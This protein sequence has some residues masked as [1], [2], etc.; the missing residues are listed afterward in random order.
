MTLTQLILSREHCQTGTRSFFVATTTKKTKNNFHNNR[1][2]QFTIATYIA[3]MSTSIMEKVDNMYTYDP[4]SGIICIACQVSVR[5]TEGRSIQYLVRVHEGLERHKKSGQRLTTEAEQEYIAKTFDS[6]IVESVKKVQRCLPCVDTANNAFISQIGTPNLYD[7]CTRCDALTLDKPNHNSR[8]CRGKL[9]TKKTGVVNIHCVHANPIIVIID[10]KFDIRNDNVQQRYACAQFRKQ[11]NGT[12]T[13]AK[14]AKAP[15]KTLEALKNQLL[16]FDNECQTMVIHDIDNRSTPN[17]YV[18]ALSWDTATKNCS[19][20]NICDMKVAD[21]H[22]NYE[23]NLRDILVRFEKSMWHALTLSK[24]LH[25]GH[26]VLCEMGTRDSGETKPPLNLKLN[27]STWTNYFRYMKTIVLLLFR[28]NDTA[29]MY[30]QQHSLPNIIFTTEQLDLMDACRTQPVDDTNNNDNNNIEDYHEVHLRFLLSFLNQFIGK[31]TYECPLI[32]ALA[33]MAIDRFSFA[34]AKNLSSTVG[35]ITTVYRML[36][37]YDCL[38]KSRGVDDNDTSAKSMEVWA[39]EDAERYLHTKSNK[40][41][42]NPCRELLKCFST[43]K[44]ESDDTAS[45]ANVSWS[46]DKKTISLLGKFS[47]SMKEL[48]DSVALGVTN[49]NDILMNLLGYDDLPAIPW[50]VITDNPS[51]QKRGFS[52][53][54]DPRNKHWVCKEVYFDK[55]YLTKMS[56]WDTND[57]TLNPHGP[58][59]TSGRY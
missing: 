31:R 57:G 25:A 39:I 16:V 56:W 14:L 52:F 12:T 46:I 44:R 58:I 40:Y 15:D 2:K 23:N 53:L 20:S 33:M 3:Y 21:R 5:T 55:I 37:V 34:T 59:N 19:F 49:A 43:I 36:L 41:R 11:W 4:S 42:S 54:D 17:L 6:F 29:N 28:V 10:E 24:T 32:G 18:T 35:G 1:C 22:G 30:H 27:D 51:E 38:R 13:T 8:H 50:D 47:M 45:E 48:Q 9:E 7:Y 26:P